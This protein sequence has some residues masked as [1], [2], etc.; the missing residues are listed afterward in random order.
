MN[1]CSQS[2]R[3]K[4]AVFNPKHATLS[5]AMMGEAARLFRFS[6]V[7]C[8]KKIR[9]FA[10]KQRS[11]L[12]CFGFFGRNFAK[13]RLPNLFSRFRAANVSAA[14]GMFGGV[15]Y[16]GKAFK[17]F[18]SVVSLITVDVV[19]MLVGVKRLQ[20]ASRNNTVHK[21]APAE[22]KIAQRVFCGCIGKMISENFSTARNGV[23]V[24][25][26]SILDSVYLD[27]NHVVPFKVAKES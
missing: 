9:T 16:S 24:V 5:V 1:A 7:R 4:R 23:K 19:D 27:A 15:F 12:F 22:R 3:C 21:S 25:K 17:V 14:S 2:R 10:A 6:T 13:P 26:E 20:P 11:T 8:A 18:H